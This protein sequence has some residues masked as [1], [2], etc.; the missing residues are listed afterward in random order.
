MGSTESMVWPPAIG[1]PASR[2]AAS[3]PRMIWPMTS[4]GNWAMGMATSASAM[5]GR[6]PM[7]Y[8]SLMALVAAM[9]PKSKGSSTMGMK[10]SVVAISACSSLSR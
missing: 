9:R 5:M 8:T 4:T 7:A 6:P 1:I 2:H 10:K 3:P